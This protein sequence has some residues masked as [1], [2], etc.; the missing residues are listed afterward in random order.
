MMTKIC[1]LT[2][3]AA[4]LCLI[5]ANQTLVG[6]DTASVPPL[7]PATATPPPGA[8]PAGVQHIR[9]GPATPADLA[10]IAR[11][12]QLPELTPGAGDGDY[13]LRAPHTPAPEQTPRP[14]VPKGKIVHFTMAAAESKF[15]PDTGL[16]GTTPTRDVTVYIPDGYVPGTS[17]P[18]LV[19]QDAMGGHNSSQLVTILDNMIAVHRL[20]AMVA[21]MIRSGGGDDRGSERGLEYDTLSG[22]YAEFIE[23]EV[24][25]RVA[26]ECNVTITKDPAARATIG[27]SSGGTAAFTMAWFHPE[28]YHRV[29]TYTA[30][31]TNNQ[32]PENA[33]TPHGAWEYHEHLIPQGAAK[34]LRVWLEVNEND[35]GSTTSAA[36]MHNLVIANQRMAGALKAKGYHYQF[37]Y[38]LGAGRF[39]AAGQGHDDANVIAQTL[40]HALEWLWQDYRPSR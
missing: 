17:A 15:Y 26:R 18:L 5:P 13:L 10:E 29:L 11:L 23:V 39:Y 6:A 20:P 35:T 33:A 9:G 31:Y 36:D 14:D 2:V 1:P 4:A 25:P 27:G 40:P 21:V 28:L 37:V 19:S 30:T 24:L 22:K 7:P 38:A 32:S 12:G 34:P 16:R 8:D 3:A